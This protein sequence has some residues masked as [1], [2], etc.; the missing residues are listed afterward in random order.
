MN[1]LEVIY[2]SEDEF[3]V[4]TTCGDQMLLM[5]DKY[6]EMLKEASV[7][8]QCEPLF[9]NTSIHHLLNKTKKV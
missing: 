9:L 5:L 3:W 2:K 8:L 4:I 1:V 6:Y 7:L